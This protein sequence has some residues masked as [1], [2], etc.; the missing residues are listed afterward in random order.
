MRLLGKGYVEGEETPALLR[1]LITELE[2][3]LPSLHP[4]MILAVG[5]AFL[6]ALFNLMTRHLAAYDP[7]ETIQYLPAVGAAIGLT[8]FAIAVWEWP[9]GMLEWTVAC[10][11]GVMGGLGHYLL[12]LA[13]RYAPAS[14]LSPFLY[15]QVVYM[16]LF[17]YLVFGDVPSSNVWI[18]SAIV[19]A[20]GLYL[21][22]RERARRVTEAAIALLGPIAAKSADDYL[23]AVAEDETGLQIAAESVKT[24]YPGLGLPPGDPRQKVVQQVNATQAASGAFGGAFGAPEVVQGVVARGVIESQ[25]SWLKEF[26]TPPTERD[27][28]GFYERSAYW[29]RPELKEN[30]K[31][32]IGLVR[33]LPVEQPA[34]GEAPPP[35]PPGQPM[36]R[37]VPQVVK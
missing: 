19:I 31:Q 28:S 7:P 36:A 6:Y 26:K 32:K 20:S 30:I 12:A 22:V 37:P 23:Q 16:A 3:A 11:L 15:Q 4:A 35:G 27:A 1:E 24:V 18:G 5:N 33:K 8:P 13:H 34:D 29:V 21:F 2:S 25:Y 10:L 14:I 17:G 9:A